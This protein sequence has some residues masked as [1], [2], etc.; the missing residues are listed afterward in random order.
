MATLS[1]GKRR[2]VKFAYKMQWLQALQDWVRGEMQA[3][4]R[5]VLV[6]DFNV[7]PEDRDSTISGL[8]DTIHHTKEE[9]AHFQALLAQSLADAYRMFSSPTRAIRGG[10]TECGFP[11]KP[12][13]AY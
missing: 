8:A 3:H 4:E 5:L 2:T 13:P 12:G 11:E 1:T 9:R 7:A 6:G 10:T